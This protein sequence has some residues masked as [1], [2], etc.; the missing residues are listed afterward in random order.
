M[1]L[2]LGLDV[3]GTSSRALIT[4]L[5]GARAGFGRAGAGNPVSVPLADAVASVADAVRAALSGLDP[6]EVRAAVMG[7]AGTGRF[8]DPVVAAAFGQ[9]FAG[10]GLTVPVRPVG[11]VLVAY[12]AGTA[13]PSGSVLISGTGAIAARIESGEMT[14]T[15]DGIGWL[16]GDLGS[17]FWLGREAAALTARELYTRVPQGRLTRSVAT[18]VLGT[19]PAAA[20]RQAAD[21][22]IGALHAEPP[23]HLSRLAPLVTDAAA[24]GDP[25]ALALVDR[26]AAH[27]TDCLAE[28]HT[29]GPVVLAGS[30]LTT[31]APV[32]DALIR[33]LADRLPGTAIAVAG[34]GE[35][36][37]ARLAARLVT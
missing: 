13:E 20:S 11:D 35:A 16:L 21:D 22:L 30:V 28:V 27:L 37:A 18:T 31:S 17:G 36:G 25:Q 24:H 14:G 5:D 9:A 7:I 3:G 8:A 26:A 6:S 29:D 32:R 19:I 15:A 10:L 33:L 34:P 12:A 2:V 4:T 23:R 1:T